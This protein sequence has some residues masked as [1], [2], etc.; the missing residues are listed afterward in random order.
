[1]ES[2][3]LVLANLYAIKINFSR[4]KKDAK[5]LNFLHEASIADFK[6]L[7]RWHIKGNWIKETYLFKINPTVHQENNVQKEVGLTT[8]L[9]I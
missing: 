6:T 8:E 4:N 9:Q 7:Q 2:F 3:R 1:M 5:P